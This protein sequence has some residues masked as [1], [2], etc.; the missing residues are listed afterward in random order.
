MQH[1]SGDF[2]SVGKIGDSG[3]NN[4]HS[5]FIYSLLN[6][7]TDSCRHYIAGAPKATVVGHA[8]ACGIH[9]GSHVVRIKADDVAQGAVALEGKVFLIVI[10]VEHGLCSIGH[11]PCNR[12]T[13]IH[14]I[15]EAVVDFLAAVVQGHDFQGNFV[16][17]GISLS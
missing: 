14:G 11:P 3:F 16:G 15:A 7:I 5:G 2:R 6:F 17:D 8:V 12:D 9:V 1:D 4:F 10:H 13:D